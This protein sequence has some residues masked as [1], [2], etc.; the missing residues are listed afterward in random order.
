MSLGIN[1]AYLPSDHYTVKAGIPV[2]MVIN[3]VGTGCRS[4]F[5]IPKEK[6]SIPL[7]QEVNTVSFTPEKKG[8][9][10]FRCSMGMYSGTINV[11]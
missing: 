10:T 3:G 4:V 6:I 9:L 11:I 2:K 7:N 5:T 1:P 8:R